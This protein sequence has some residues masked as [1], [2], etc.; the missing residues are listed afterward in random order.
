MNDFIKKIQNTSTEERVMIDEKSK[1]LLLEIPLLSRILQCAITELHD[2]SI[3]DIENLL[4][5]REEIS[6]SIEPSTKTSIES[7]D[8]EITIP[9][10]GKMECDL[11]IKLNIDSD[12]ERL[13]ID[14]EAQ[15]KEKPR[16]RPCN[17]WYS[18]CLSN[19]FDAIWQRI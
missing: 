9:N 13:Y 2:F 14:V 5:T 19:Y 12:E 10:E 18:L 16:I 4:K 7:D 8:K 15:N 1:A 6:K 11:R 17:S 3:E